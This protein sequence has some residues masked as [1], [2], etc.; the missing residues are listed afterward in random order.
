M[1]DRARDVFHAL[2]EDAAAWCE[3]RSPWPRWPLYAY[4]VYAAVRHLFDAEYRSWFG[5]LTLVVHEAGHLLFSPFGQTLM[6]LGGSITQLAVPLFVGIYL[7]VRQKDWFGLVVGGAWLSF[8]SFE[9][10]TY[11][12][13][14]N[15]G[16]LGLVG[17]GDNVMHDWDVL[18]TQ[19]G[20]LNYCEAFASVIRVGASLIGAAALALGGWLLWTMHRSRSERS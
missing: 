2:R 15:K 6:L 9:L 14:A 8:S 16:N 10:A 3:G 20:V 19:W 13:D 18:L 4:L 1:L 5:A 12:A 17:F 11:V 7:L